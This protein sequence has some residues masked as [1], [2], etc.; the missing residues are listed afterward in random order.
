MHLPWLTEP[1]SARTRHRGN[2]SAS[3]P[4][5]PAPTR[6]SSTAASP[7]SR[8]QKVTS[9][10]SLSTQSQMKLLPQ[11]TYP[12]CPIWALKAYDEDSAVWPCLYPTWPYSSA[13]IAPYQIL[14]RVLSDKSDA[15]SME[16][17]P[18]RTKGVLEAV[19]MPN[20]QSSSSSP[21]GMPFGGAGGCRGGVFCY[22]ILARGKRYIP[23]RKRTIFWSFLENAVLV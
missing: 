16:I 7:C 21:T 1:I 5:A 19:L 4:G 17:G 12:P 3:P 10:T 13:I 2:G 15:H 9:E 20:W 14:L 18:R 8:S 23:A 6:A 22:A 11:V